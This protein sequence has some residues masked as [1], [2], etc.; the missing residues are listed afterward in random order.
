MN[1]IRAAT[2]MAATLVLAAAGWALY[3]QGQDWWDIGRAPEPS[4]PTREIEFKTEPSGKTLALTDWAGGRIVVKG[5]GNADLRTSANMAQAR[6]KAEEAARAVAA[7]RIAEILDGI[8]LTS[9]RTVQQGGM[10]NATVRLRVDAFIKGIQYGEPRLQSNPDGSIWAEVTATLGFFGNGGL[11]DTI[12]DT[13]PPSDPSQRKDLPPPAP[14]APESYT[15]LIV[16]ASGLGVRPGLA[17][18]ILTETRREVYGTADVSR[19]YV[20]KYGMVGYAKS[21]DDARGFA[22]RVGKNPLVV[23]AVGPEEPNGIG[24]ILSSE[25]AGKALAADRDGRALKEARVIFVLN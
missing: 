25:D 14:K 2:S 16:D 10:E 4:T 7:G 23:K 11:V 12:Q 17:P 9:D 21:V 8:H 18:R 19:D 13:L 5:A 24:V 15:G 22:D 1:T 3:A 20:I 6:W